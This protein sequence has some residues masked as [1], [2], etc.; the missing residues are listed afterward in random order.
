MT[1]K[2]LELW[3]QYGEHL[4]PIMPF[5]DNV[6]E[7]SEG[8]YLID[9]EGNRILDLAAGQFC[10]ILGH[11]HPA[12]VQAV[13]DELQNN[14]HLG[15]QYVTEGILKA[16]RMVSEITPGDLNNIIFLSTGSEANEFAMR[17]AKACQ[18]R[19]GMIGFDRGYYGISLATRS[20]S[21]I[22][23]GSGHVDFT[24][25]SPE[26][27][28]L[29]APDTRSGDGQRELES[30]NTSI[31]LIGD[32][33]ESVA[34]IVVE[35][36]LSAG[37]MIFPSADYMQALRQY[38]DDIGALLIV[39]E[40]QTGFGRCG[41]WFDCTNLGVTPDILVFSKTSGNGFPSSGVAISDR[42]KTKLVNRNFYHL[43]S[44]QNDALTAAAVSAVIRTIRDDGYLDRAKEQGAYFIERLNDLAVRHGHLTNVRGRGLMIAF[45]LDPRLGTDSVVPNGLTLFVLACKDRG[46]HVTYTYYE[47][48]IRILP[49]IS[50]SRE[51]IDFA[52]EVFDTVLSQLAEG[53]IDYG[54]VEQ[55][56]KVIQSMLGKSKVARKLH[57]IWETSPS[58]WFA[59]L[60]KRMK[61]G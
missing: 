36:V 24:P 40:A 17:V 13:V 29:I 16:A 55:K 9:V 6:I 21:A 7:R 61:T 43:S 34:A 50:I 18:Q 20:L 51:E 31:K 56:N 46:V 26:T 25:K 22:S 10:T 54:D 15:C 41:E 5:M 59:K 44:H 35:T 33:A 8:S 37:G 60:G 23:A 42:L 47:Q 12:V 49:A 19:N 30:L 39:D 28:H 11:N 58:Y 2:N 45:D 32:Y 57:R 4:I 27:H 3:N 52:I 38:A 53:K 14:L 48:S 1:R